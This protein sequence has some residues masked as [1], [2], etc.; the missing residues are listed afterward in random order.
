MEAFPVFSFTHNVVLLS[1]IRTELSR[2]IVVVKKK[3]IYIYIQGN[4]GI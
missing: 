4:L 2:K 1:F 3:N